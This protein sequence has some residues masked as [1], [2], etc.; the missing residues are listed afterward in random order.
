[1]PS[2][3]HA[4][5]VVVPDRI[6]PSHSAVQEGGGAE[7]MEFGGIVGEGS[8]FKGIQ[9]LWAP[10]LDGYLLQIPGESDIGP[11]L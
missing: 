10:P 4:G 1:M 3:Q 6:A 9:R 11:R 5:A 8:N 2:V 7:A